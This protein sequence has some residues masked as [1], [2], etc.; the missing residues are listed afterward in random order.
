[1]TLFHL[2]IILI[3]SHERRNSHFH[4][5]LP[6]HA[7]AR[8]GKEERS[9]SRLQSGYPPAVWDRY[10]K[11]MNLNYDMVIESLNTW[12][13]DELLFQEYYEME[14]TPETIFAFY[15]KHKDDPYN[16]SI[17]MHPELLPSRQDEEAFMRVSQNAVLIKHPRYC[18]FYFHEHSYFEMIYVISGSCMQS[19]GRDQEIELS[20]GDLCILAPD[21]VHGISAFRDCLVMNILIRRS[22]F[23]DIFMNTIR[24]K[25]QIG[26]FFMENLFAKKKYPYLLFHTGKDM[27][28]RNYILDMYLEQTNEDEF[29]D[30]IICSLLTIFFTQLT[31]RHKK[32]M[33]LSSA[34][35]SKR[36][37]E[38]ALV[39]Y[40][41]NNY[42]TVT[43]E[44]LSRKFYYSV[45]YCSKV[46]KDFSGSTFSELLTSVRLQ[47]G[48][49]FLLLTQM[50]VADISARLGYKNPE[51]FIRVFQRYHHMT[52]SQYRRQNAF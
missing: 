26:L 23:M 46:I 35:K 16:T 37:N 20:E 9:S 7:A 41:L 50:S 31:R 10:G 33:E 36:G 48:E 30:R 4:G 52:P 39:N 5:C 27:V 3:Y 17:V 47:Q 21:V 32:T 22:T 18:P 19:F 28:V 38:E 40:I 2:R 25:S 34:G 1:M 13:K 42:Q 29:S 49:N 14:K 15:E 11:N 51:T 6:S 8:S 24:D 12:N 44:E 45:P 43:L